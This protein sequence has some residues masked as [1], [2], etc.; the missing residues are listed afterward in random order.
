MARQQIGL[1]AILDT[2]NFDA[3]MLKYIAGI[4]GMNT[5][6]GRAAGAMTEG[7]SSLGGVLTGAVVGG[8]GLAAYGATRATKGVVGYISD[9]LDTAI[10][11]EQRLA[12]VAGILGTDYSGVAPLEELA[13]QLGLDPKLKVSTSE[14]AD[15]MIMLA[16]Q[17]LKVEDIVGGAARET[18]LLA[19]AT[20]AGFETAA[21]VMVT[22]MRA[23]GLETKDFSRI[24]DT[25]TNVV[26]NSRF[27]IDDWA[28]ALAR[29]GGVAAAAGMTFQDFGAEFIARAVNFSSGGDFGTAEKIFS[30]RIIPKSKEAA[31]VMKELGL[32]TGN[33]G[34][35]FDDAL[36]DVEKFN[37]K[38]SKLD[39]SSKTYEKKLAEYT[40]ELQ[41]AEAKVAAGMGQNKFF[42]EFG[43]RQSTRNIILAMQEAFAGLTEAQRID[44]AHE[45]FGTDAMR[46]ALSM[47]ELPIEE[48]DK[49]A[50]AVAE[51]GTAQKSA[52]TR[53]Q[54]LQSRME[55]LDDIMTELNRQVGKEFQ[56]SFSDVI[57]S[58]ITLASDVGPEV[59]E[60]FGELADGVGKVVEKFL[61]WAKVNLEP[62]ISQLSNLG[63]WAIGW[64]FEGDP[65]NDWITHLD[66]NFQK[67]A[68]RL[69]EIKQAW[70]DFKEKFKSGWEQF[71]EAIAPLT[72]FLAKFVTWK[73][74]LAAA[75]LSIGVFLAPFAIFLAKM[76]LAG[77]TAAVAIAAIRKAWNEDF[78]QIATK[79][80]EIVEDLKGIFEELKELWGNIFGDGSGLGRWLETTVQQFMAFF[81]SITGAT[82]EF[83]AAINALFEGDWAAVWEHLKASWQELW[84]GILEI[85]GLAMDQIAGYFGYDSWQE[86]FAGVIEAFDG[87]WT[88]LQGFFEAWKIGFEE[89]FTWIQEKWTAFA[90]FFSEQWQIF[91][92]EWTQGWEETFTAAKEGWDAFKEWISEKWQSIMDFFTESWETFKEEW[93]QGWEDT[94]QAAKDAWDGF[95]E[96]VEEKWQAIVDFFKD[97]FQE[98][99]DDW[100]NS[101]EETI[102]SVKD[103]MDEFKTFLSDTWENIKQ[104]AIDAWESIKTGVTDAAQAVVDSVVSAFEGLR[105]KVVSIFTGLL[106]AVKGAL[107]PSGWF[108]LG[109]SAGEGVVAGLNSQVA[110][111]QAAGAALAAAASTATADT[112]QVAS[113]SKVF[114]R[115]GEMSGLGLVE[116]LQSK[117]AEVS[118]KAR[119]ATSGFIAQAGRNFEMQ[120]YGGGGQYMYR[121]G[122]PS[123]SAI[124]IQI[125]PNHIYS[126]MEMAEFE[127]RV[128]A[129][130]V[131]GL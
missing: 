48:W 108:S 114:R 30:Q 104:G 12:N 89:V 122:L 11:L 102:Q 15:V 52:E 92:E 46:V 16:K 31:R 51:S 18:I 103:K 44:Y 26:N 21:D 53:T 129:A 54:A 61:E 19:N 10:D 119:L 78:G 95:K 7:L 8:V 87:F 39:P 88:T 84:D 120:A 33:T 93:K 98:F 97:K 121:A 40:A 105:D 85:L 3:G 9:G 81:E 111:A 80:K 14:A 47:L 90:E 58:L 63:K 25:A 2:S 99:K 117:I 5:V 4:E 65:F 67:F 123:S 55:V 83:L 72:E 28:L 57:E 20:G 45:I 71:R 24:V 32:I 68:L 86:M 37:D 130:V 76:A 29:G 64:A 74:V 42:D 22:S 6:T 41:A 1:E 43:N 77:T 109:Q 115:F 75:A 73:D 17:G 112:L 116:G 110:A 62:I 113:P 50:A 127:S 126:G 70:D 60:L 100:T 82:K 34:D 36:E 23:F 59:I 124:N 94:F 38:I 35:E 56:D 27:D 106:D 96:A 79:T 107:N 13:S 101:W 128:R 66:E 118:N 125:G 131:R 49:Y 69:I 91:K